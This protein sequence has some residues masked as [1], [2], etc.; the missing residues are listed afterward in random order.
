ML[1]LSADKR[2]LFAYRCTRRHAWPVG[3][4]VSTGRFRG[5]PREGKARSGSIDVDSIVSQ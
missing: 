3:W 1:K 5:N 2:G 4:K